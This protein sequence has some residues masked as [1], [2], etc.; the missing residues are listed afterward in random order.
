MLRITRYAGINTAAHLQGVLTECR[1]SQGKVS[2]STL[3]NPIKYGVLKADVH[4]L[5]LKQVAADGDGS[6]G[7][8]Q[9]A[10]EDAKKSKYSTYF[11]RAAGR[12]GSDSS[13]RGHVWRAGEDVCAAAGYSRLR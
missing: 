1:R 8:K 3:S 5:R 11:I 10:A 13:S 6:H 4:N 12:G 9:Q 2:S 7:Y